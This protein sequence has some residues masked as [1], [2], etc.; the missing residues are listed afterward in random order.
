M[1]KISFFFLCSF[2]FLSEIDQV[3]KKRES[4][5]YFEEEPKL[6]VN[7]APRPKLYILNDSNNLRQKTYIFYLLK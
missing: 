5:C 3:D 4:C 7:I 1:I 2:K 6:G